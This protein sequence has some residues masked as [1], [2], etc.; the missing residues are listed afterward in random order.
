MSFNVGNFHSRF[1]G[2]ISLATQLS[3]HPG[4]SDHT[5]H[6]GFGELDNHG[7]HGLQSVLWHNTHILVKEPV[8]ICA[9]LNEITRHQFEGGSA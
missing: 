1:P 7:Q 6:A 4:P 2:R 5:L 8:T 9:Y 3:P